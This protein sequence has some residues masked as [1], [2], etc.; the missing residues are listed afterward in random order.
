M[1]E[2]KICVIGV[3]FGKLP[4]YFDL[5]LQSAAYNSKVDFLIFTNQ[6]KKELPKNVRFIEMT[7]AQM[8]KRASKVLGFSAVLDQPYKC[9]DYK[10][11]YGLIFNDYITKYE[12]WAHTDFDLIY[13]DLLFFIE[14]YQM[15]RY[16]KF[17]PLGHLSFYRNIAESNYHFMA[18]GAKYDYKKVYT[19]KNNFAFDEMNG[20]IAIYKSN[21]FSFFKKKVML[22]ITEAHHRFTQ[23]SLTI[24]DNEIVTNYDYQVFYWENGKVYRAYYENGI[25]NTEEY[26]Y[27]H[28]KRRPNFDVPFDIHTTSAFYINADGFHKKCEDVTLETIKQHNPFP[29]VSFEIK[30]KKK[31]D[32]K[33]KFKYYK[34]AFRKRILGVLQR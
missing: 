3:Y 26:M 25:I 17:L 5:W 33:E 11:I 19:N 31:Y 6:K 27:I 1:M 21:N 14:K 7:L 12:Y 34:D 23:G 29:G 30:E 8:Q 4:N 20:L 9:C 18:D 22:D 24:E 32:R 28:F 13:G 10:V 2:N 15:Y 16:D